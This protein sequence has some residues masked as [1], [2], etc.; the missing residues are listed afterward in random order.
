VIANQVVPFLID[1]PQ[2][3][4]ALNDFIAQLGCG[5]IVYVHAAR[6]GVFQQTV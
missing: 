1:G 4:L 5:W 2:Q 6:Q 3:W